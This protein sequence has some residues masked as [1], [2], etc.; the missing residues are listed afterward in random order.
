MFICSF[1]ASVDIKFFS[2][3]LSK[4]NL[5]IIPL[6]LMESRITRNVA[7][8]VETFFF[9]RPIRIV[10]KMINGDDGKTEGSH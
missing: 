1:S 5:L 10:C 9:L 2:I 4:K 3:I 7:V 6:T 8:F